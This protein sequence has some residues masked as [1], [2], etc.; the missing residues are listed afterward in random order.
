MIKLSNAAVIELKAAFPYSSN[1][2]LAEQYGT[3]VEYMKQFGHR[4]VLKKCSEVVTKARSKAARITNQIR[5]H[6]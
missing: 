6:K 5:W 4:H 3:S 1:K 2:E